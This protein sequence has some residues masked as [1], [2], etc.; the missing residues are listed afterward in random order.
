MAEI[1]RT[2]DDAALLAASAAG[3]RAAFATLY[4]RHLG[5]VVGFLVIETGDR[6]LAGDL[7]AGQTVT[8]AGRRS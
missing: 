3:D 5:P 8:S 1:E 2:E 7:A 4:R 6:E